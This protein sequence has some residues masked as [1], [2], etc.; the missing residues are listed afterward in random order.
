[1][2]S[3]LVESVLLALVGGIVAGVLVLPLNRLSTAVGNS[4]TMSDVVV[5]FK[6]GPGVLLVGIVYSA[7]LGIAGGLLPAR[8]AAR[9]RIVTALR[10]V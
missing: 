10:E 1:M 8:M 7:L 6:V 4:V 5:N 2:L 9:R 3:F